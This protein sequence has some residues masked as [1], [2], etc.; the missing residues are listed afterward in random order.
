MAEVQDGSS[1][2]VAFQCSPALRAAVERQAELEGLSLSAVARRAVLRDLVHSGQHGP[3]E[4]E[5]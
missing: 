3:E 1:R 4:R 2:I 5:D